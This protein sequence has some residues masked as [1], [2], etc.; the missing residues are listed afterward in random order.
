MNNILLVLSLLF[1]LSL[2]SYD[3]PGWYVTRYHKDSFR[4]TPNARSL[5]I[6]LKYN[7]THAFLFG[8][9][10]ERISNALGRNTFYNDMWWMDASNP[11]LIKW[12]KIE[13]N[14]M[15]PSPRGYECGVYSSKLDAFFLY[16]GLVYPGVRI[17]GVILNPGEI[18]VFHFSNFSWSLLDPVSPAG[19]RGGHQ[20]EMD[21]S[22]DNAI[23]TQ[24][25]PDN[26]TS[27]NSFISDVW[28]WNLAT[29]T[30]TNITL[31][32]G[33]RPVGR[34]LFS[35]ERFP[36]TNI[37]LLLHGKRI[38]NEYR[39]DIWKFDADTYEW[40]E[41]SVTD[42]P[43]PPKEL[44]AY[45]L[46][47]KKWLLMMGGDAD[48]NLTL[49][50]TCPPPLNPCFAIVNPTDDNFFLRLNLH[51]NSADWDIS[52]P[53][54]FEHRTTP[55]RHGVIVK[56]KPYLYFYGGHDWDGTH[57]IGEIFNTLL[58]A[59]KLPNKYWD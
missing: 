9:Y 2:A 15:P 22:G 52:E 31:E 56:M 39:T 49:T 43:N 35:F 57:G 34:W 29:N 37:F 42:Q 10:R 12:S 1:T 59:N 41:L 14:T 23:V 47:S 48:G 25:I 8:G 28:K 55:H 21:L 7:E 13:N 5:P 17:E 3:Q 24:G 16:G 27:F 44:A 30:W 53:Q 33:N 20:C 19:P 54:V 6:F 32:T 18:W 45:A 46:T 11:E 50:E 4:P 40:T 26:E 51:S 36:G 38:L 58:W